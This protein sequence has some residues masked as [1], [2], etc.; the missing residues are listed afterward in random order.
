MQVLSDSFY[1]SVSEDHV[2]RKYGYVHEDS[3]DTF[4]IISIKYFL[5]A[6]ICILSLN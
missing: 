5:S 3:K 6:S 4:L 1:F 2:V